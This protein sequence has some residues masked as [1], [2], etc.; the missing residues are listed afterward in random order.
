[1]FITTDMRDE[2]LGDVTDNTMERFYSLKSSGRRGGLHQTIIT[3][4]SGTDLF[5]GSLAGMTRVLPRVLLFSYPGYF[6]NLAGLW[7]R[8]Q[9][10]SCSLLPQSFDNAVH[11]SARFA[12]RV[13]SFR[14][15]DLFHGTNRTLKP[16]CKH[17]CSTPLSH[18]NTDY[19]CVFS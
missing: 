10:C 6:T 18:E 13:K 19:P 14:I 15:I 5:S 12:R 4:W 8:H 7:A 3:P 2:N 9:G 1:M 17:Q 11:E 16:S